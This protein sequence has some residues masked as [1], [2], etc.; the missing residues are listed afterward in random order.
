MR[1]LLVLTI[2]LALS[3]VLSCSDSVTGPD[4]DDRV[5]PADFNIL[6]E[7]A[8]SF[9]E[10][11]VDSNGNRIDVDSTNGVLTFN[12][13]GTY[14]FFFKVEPYYEL[15]WNGT[16]MLTW[17]TLTWSGDITNYFPSEMVLSMYSSQF[18]CIDLDTDE[19]TFSY[20][21]STPGPETGTV[22]DID[23]NVYQTVKI[24]SQ[25]WM[26]ENLAVT[27][28]RN[29][30]PIPHHSDF[31]TWCDLSTGARSDCPDQSNYVEQYGRWYNA[32]AVQDSRGLAPAGWHIPTQAEWQELIQHLGGSDAAWGKLCEKGTSH[33]HAPHQ[34]VT[35]Q[36]GF[37]ARGAGELPCT[38]S[39]EPASGCPDV[40]RQ[41]YFWSS[42]E[43]SKGARSYG[44]HLYDYGYAHGVHMGFTYHNEFG[45]SIRCV[46]N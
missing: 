29:G 33:W 40:K 37:S 3:L 16:Y 25:W 39:V 32:Y 45:M 21:H 9:V 35:D 28:Y 10:G 5:S 22:T 41:T 27:H 24:G 38:G 13:D 34:F 44:V 36:S 1:N 12:A 19:W 15:Q 7:W 4:G 11:A 6:A 23:G 20:M 8:V 30:D 46:K 42:S 26:A 31:S 43:E 18:K 2:L 17:D 14:S